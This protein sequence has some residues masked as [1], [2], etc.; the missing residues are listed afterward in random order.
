MKKAIIIGMLICALGNQTEA[1][2]IGVKAPQNT[3][4]TMAE[5][6]KVKKVN[7]KK[8]FQITAQDAAGRIWQ[9]YDNNDDQWQ[10][11]DFAALIMHNNGTKKVNDDYV[12]N[13]RYCGAKKFF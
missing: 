1:K 6:Q 9:W 5:V 10:K 4:A 13:A 8:Y 12:L 2:V 7:G 11:K 3:Y